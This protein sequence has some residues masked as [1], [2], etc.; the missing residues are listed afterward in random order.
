M[1]ATPAGAFT[2]PMLAAEAASRERLRRPA[3]FPENIDDARSAFEQWL[4]HIR[5][6]FG[7]HVDAA[8]SNAV[9][10]RR[11]RIQALQPMLILDRDHSMDR[12]R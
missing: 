6:E 8:V 3:L 10:I 9:V 2:Q 4:D 11:S 5:V 1:T 12:D 7:R